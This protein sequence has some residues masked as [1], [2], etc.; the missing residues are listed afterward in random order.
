MAD[1]SLHVDEHL[2]SIMPVL[3]LNFGVSEDFM[4]LTIVLLQILSFR[5]HLPPYH[6]GTKTTAGLHSN[7]YREI[8]PFMLFLL[9]MYDSLPAECIIRSSYRLACATLCDLTCTLLLQ[10]PKTEQI[11][12]SAYVFHMRIQYT[13]KIMPVII[14]SSF[15]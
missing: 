1:L 12:R 3:L 7:I 4:G 13:N 6:S 15:P 2:L 9:K 10:E 11:G 8:P 5:F 14:S